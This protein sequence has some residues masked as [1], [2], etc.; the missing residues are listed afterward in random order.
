MPTIYFKRWKD[1]RILRVK[2]KYAIEHLSIKIQFEP[3]EFT[4]YYHYRKQKKLDQIKELTKAK[5]QVI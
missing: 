5:A 4:T 2:H 3:G 1:G